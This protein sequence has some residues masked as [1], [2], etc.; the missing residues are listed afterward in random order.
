MNELN[1]II[2]D[3]EFYTDVPDCIFSG[4]DYKDHILRAF[5]TT[6]GILKLDDFSSAYKDGRFEFN[7]IVNG[8]TSAFSVERQSDYINLP[9]FEEGLNKILQ[10]NGYKGEKKF[11]CF[12][13]AEMDYA[14]AFISEA[15]YQ[16]IRSNLM[17]FSIG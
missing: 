6:N 13:S 5:K 12:G 11:I 15:K 7:L 4:N 8:K 10:E 17:Q 2:S 16:E 14:L 9:E 3:D 1:D